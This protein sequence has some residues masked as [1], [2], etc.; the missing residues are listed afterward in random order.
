MNGK[1]KKK[2]R[3]T[4]EGSRGLETVS[5]GVFVRYGRLIEGTNVDEHHLRVKDFKEERTG[6][7]GKEGGQSS[8][9]SGTIGRKQVLVGEA[10]TRSWG[11]RSICQRKKIKRKGQGGN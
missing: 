11:E 6:G 10:N 8:D 1:R 7:G 5:G 4:G 3:V 9:L 2:K